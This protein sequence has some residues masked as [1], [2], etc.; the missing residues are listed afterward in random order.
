MAP[1]FSYQNILDHRQGKVK[2]LGSEFNKLLAAQQEAEIR[3]ASLQEFQ[4]SLLDQLKDAQRSNLDLSQIRLLRLNIAQVN[5]H[6]EN[7]SLELARLN[8]AIQT[9]GLS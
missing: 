4:Y 3:L 1:K 6:S 2:F 9:K 7:V 5:T 8:R